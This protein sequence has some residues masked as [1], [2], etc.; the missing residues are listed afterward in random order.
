MHIEIRSNFVKLE[1]Y[2]NAVARDSKV[3][4][5]NGREFVEQVVPGAWKKALSANDNIKLLFNHDHNR[6]LGSMKNG[7]LKLKE[8]NIGL[9]ATCTIYDGE[10]IQKAKEGKLKGWSFGFSIIDDSYEKFN[11]MERRYIKELKLLEVS[12]LDITPAYVGT[13]IESRNEN[14]RKVEIRTMKNPDKRNKLKE[15]LELLESEK[16]SIVFK[17]KLENRSL[18]ENESERVED[19]N[20]QIEGMKKDMKLKEDNEN[21]KNEKRAL[22]EEEFRNSQDKKTEVRMLK[23]VV[24]PNEKMNFETRNKRGLDFGKLVKGMSGKGWSGAEEERNYYNSMSSNNNVLVP[25]DIANQIVDVARSQSAIVGQVPIMPMKHNNLTIITQTKDAEA[26]F[27]NEGDLIPSSDAVFKGA[28]LKG[29]TLAIFVPINLELLESAE[30]LDTQLQAT[31]AR[32]IV[33]ALDKALMYGKGE[34]TES[35]PNDEIKGV[36]LYDTVNNI[37]HTTAD[38]DLVIK[39]AKAIKNANLFPT[40][41]CYNTDLASDIAMLKDSTGQYISM[42]NAISSYIQT[43][44]NNLKANEALVYD[45]NSMI[46]GLHQDI[47]MEWGTTQDMFQRLQVGLRIY[48]RADLAVVNPKGISVVEVSA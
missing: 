10:V 22:L 24:L 40:N 2:V 26:H 28:H 31:T 39:G 14:N 19:I 32:A 42:P 3:L 9:K 47:K 5:E 38:Y 13:S 37:S 36:T 48:L 27:V 35:N 33:Q 21:K 11:N 15:K 45:R 7:N 44:S 17:A 30:N 23:D 4:N 46:L 18:N 29:K 6:T 20:Y 25:S 12:I 8:D 43:E 16:G 1:G 41:V 34:K